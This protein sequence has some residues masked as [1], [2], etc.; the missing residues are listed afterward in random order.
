MIYYCVIQI[1]FRGFGLSVTLGFNPATWQ[2]DEVLVTNAAIID[3]LRA[4]GRF[5]AMGNNHLGRTYIAPRVRA[6]G[7][8][9]RR[10]RV[11]HHNRI[12]AISPK[13]SREFRL[14]WSNFIRL[15]TTL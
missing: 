9:D 8:V 7:A 5:L 12:T 6:F 3:W 2:I 10:R 14:S 11:N 13:T 1:P 15:I 4:Q